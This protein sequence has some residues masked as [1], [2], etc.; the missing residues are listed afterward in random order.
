MQIKLKDTLEVIAKYAFYASD[1]PVILSIENHCSLEGQRKMAQYIRSI[2]GDL[3]HTEFDPLQQELPSP[4]KLKKKIL[5]KVPFCSPNNTG[6][7][8][9]APCR[10]SGEAVCSTRSK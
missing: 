3:L 5:I 2:L 9:R 10:T 1:Y 7:R 6:P 4:A 8:A